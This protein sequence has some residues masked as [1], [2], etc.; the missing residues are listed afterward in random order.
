MT[1]SN[2]IVITLDSTKIAFT[3]LDSKPNT[4][5]RE[6]YEKDVIQK[7]KEHLGRVQQRQNRNWKPCA[8]NSC[9]NCFGTGIDSFGN[10]CVHGIYCNCPK[11]SPFY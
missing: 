8:H 4:I 10:T 7:Q 5:S 9:T 2:S 3:G 1:Y 11:C 6:D